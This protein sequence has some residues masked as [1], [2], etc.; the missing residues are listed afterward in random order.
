VKVIC[1]WC[2]REGRPSLLGER[3]PLDDPG[4]THGICR[5]HH[6]LLL[7]ELPS[8][9][10]PDVDLLLVVDPGETDLYDYLLRNLASVR[11]VKVIVDRRQADRR[12]AQ[13]Q[14]H[15]E[16]RATERRMARGRASAMGYTVVRFKAGKREE[17]PAEAD[18]NGQPGGHGGSG[19]LP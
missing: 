9:S 18:G 14:V 11:G 17:L 16:R 8:R 5:R 12:Q 13:W 2:Q 6:L 1:S 19:D 3:E 7:T 10:F 15:S 4:E